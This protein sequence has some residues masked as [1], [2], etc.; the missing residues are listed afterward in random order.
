MTA[1]ATRRYPKKKKALR[2]YVGFL[3]SQISAFFSVGDLFQSFPTDDD[4]WLAGK[5]WPQ[6][7]YNRHSE[8]KPRRVR[9]LGWRRHDRNIYG[10]V[11][12]W[13]IVSVIWMRPPLTGSR[14]SEGFSKEGGSG[15]G[16]N[17]HWLRSII[18]V[19]MSF[20]LMVQSRFCPLIT[21]LGT[22]VTVSWINNTIVSGNE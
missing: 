6:E 10:K 11:G 9:A 3:S 19:W 12:H 17:R 21:W 13:F 15:R 20:L 14:L 18:A 4:I 2:Y 7:S 1:F 8:L 16:N 5:N 22:I